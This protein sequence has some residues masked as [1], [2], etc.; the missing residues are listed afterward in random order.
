MPVHFFNPPAS[1]DAVRSELVDFV[2]QLEATGEEV[3]GTQPYGQLTAVFTRRREQ[4][5]LAI[6]GSPD[7]RPSKV[8]PARKAAR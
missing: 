7:G 5:P 4:P 2:E 8:S 1:Y 3:V 6:I